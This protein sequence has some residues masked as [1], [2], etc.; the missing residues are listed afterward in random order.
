[1]LH[2][3][4]YTQDV[5]FVYLNM[6]NIPCIANIVLQVRQQKELPRVNRTY[7]PV[8]DQNKTS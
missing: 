4:F 6:Q 2:I 7:D 5:H 8:E 1:M 3:F